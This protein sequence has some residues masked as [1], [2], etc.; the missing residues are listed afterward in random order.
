MV[1][2]IFIQYLYVQIPKFVASHR[3]VALPN[4]GQRGF[5]RY[6]RSRARA[7]IKIRNVKQEFTDVR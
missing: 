1:Y 6:V 3:W 5:T 2:T 7:K 4:Y